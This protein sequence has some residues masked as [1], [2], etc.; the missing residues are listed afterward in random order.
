MR[1]T[2]VPGNK[3]ETA[4]E[5]QAVDAFMEIAKLNGPFLLEPIS[6]DENPHLGVW[7]A[8]G[9]DIPCLALF[10]CDL[11]NWSVLRKSDLGV[12]QYLA[13]EVK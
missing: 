9:R 10:C 1:I 2:K 5:R 3:I 11:G 13:D 4:E 6:L 8:D 12:M 7:L